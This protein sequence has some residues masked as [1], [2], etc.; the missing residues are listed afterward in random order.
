[1][2]CWRA[3][4]CLRVN[5]TRMD[6]Y[7]RVACGLP[8]VLSAPL[9]RRAPALAVAIWKG[10]RPMSHER[11]AALIQTHQAALLAHPEAQ[12]THEAIINLLQ[13]VDSGDITVAQCVRLLRY[14]AL[15]VADSPA[16]AALYRQA[17]ADLQQMHRAER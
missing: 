14:Q 2:R 7:E 10:K 13:G 3:I 1:M 16:Y 9:A 5:S 6:G 4:A 8:P 11:L 15:L 17:A 12:A